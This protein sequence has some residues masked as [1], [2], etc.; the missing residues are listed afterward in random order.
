[1]SPENRKFKYTLIKQIIMNFHNETSL[2]VTWWQPP[3][4]LQTFKT[5]GRFR[6]QVPDFCNFSAKYPTK[7]L[8]KSGMFPF[9]LTKL[10]IFHQFWRKPSF[11]CNLE[12]NFHNLSKISVILG[13]V[14]HVF[15][16]VCLSPLTGWGSGRNSGNPGEGVARV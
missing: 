8:D 11:K 12:T 13:W 15:V 14:G 6:D 16:H 5:F 10:T 2:M 7:I 4:N 1:M 3:P 9:K